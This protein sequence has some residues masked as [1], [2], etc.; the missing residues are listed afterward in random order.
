MG[1]FFQLFN[2][3]TNFIF[4][5]ITLTLISA[6]ILLNI[7]FFK[8]FFPA[9]S[10][11]R[12]LA[13]VVFGILILLFLFLICKFIITIFDVTSVLFNLTQVQIRIFIS[14]VIMPVYLKF[15]KTRN[16]QIWRGSSS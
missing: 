12:G 5:N 8:L 15:F 4:H 3:Q 13:S 10:Y 7:L 11:S 6:Y 2:H 1:K 9:M 14:R 16:G